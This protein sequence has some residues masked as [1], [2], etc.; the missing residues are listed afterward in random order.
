[1]KL[2]S[3]GKIVVGYKITDNGFLRINMLLI[4]STTGKEV[5]LV[6]GS[7]SYGNL[8]KLMRY[9]ITSD[10][11]RDG[12]IQFLESCG[13]GNSIENNMSFLVPLLTE[14]APDALEKLP[15]FKPFRVEEEYGS[16]PI[17]ISPSE[18]E[19]DISYDSN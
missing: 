17:P 12:M 11:V 1:M 5:L 3:S 6:G 2:E 14:V 8:C 18:D 7:Q 19:K 10:N 16:I 15:R 13:K 9:I 4:S